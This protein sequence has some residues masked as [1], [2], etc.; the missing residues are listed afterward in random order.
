MSEVNIPFLP[1]FREW[2][3]NGTKVYTSRSKIM[4]EVG[5]TFTAFGQRFELLSVKDVS[6]YEVSLLWKEEGCLDREDFINVW[7]HIHPRKGY[8]DT[9]RT[10]LHHFKALQREGVKGKH[11]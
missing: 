10:Y 2:L 4:G 3:L 7:N 1:R 6:L 11:G 8:S 5:D 9:Q